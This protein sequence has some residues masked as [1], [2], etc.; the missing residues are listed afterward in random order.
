MQHFQDFDHFFYEI[1]RTIT[2]YTGVMK[3]ASGDVYEGE[4]YHGFMFGY[5]KYTYADGGYYEGEFR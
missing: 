2:I 1:I 3:Y 4:F 5:G